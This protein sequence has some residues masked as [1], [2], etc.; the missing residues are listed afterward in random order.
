MRFNHAVLQYKLLHSTT[1]NNLKK[2]LFS[3]ALGSLPAVFLMTMT[4]SDI[5]IFAG[6]NIWVKNH[7]NYQY[8]YSVFSKVGHFT[9]QDEL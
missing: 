2:Q 3:P 5:L 8:I 7:L 9:H 6:V 1:I 4:D